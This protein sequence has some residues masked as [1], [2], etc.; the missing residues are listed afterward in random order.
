MGISDRERLQKI[1]K[2]KH[3]VYALFDPRD[4]KPRYVGLTHDV[5]GRYKSHVAGSTRTTAPWIAELKA[6]DLLPWMQILTPVK[7]WF[8]GQQIEADCIY[9]VGL[10]Y[11]L[12]NVARSVAAVEHGERLRAEQLERRITFILFRRMRCQIRSAVFYK[13]PQD[14]SSLGFPVT[15][16]GVT[17]SIGS[18]AKEIG[19]SRQGMFERLKR[20]SVE[21]AVTTPRGQLPRLSKA[22]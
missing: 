21:V 14:A 1:H 12:L 20:H 17:K 10:V 11:P 18:W 13:L 3:F 5:D 9:Q 19:I 7:N 4:G 15:F 16:N 22:S 6:L 8:Y 2:L